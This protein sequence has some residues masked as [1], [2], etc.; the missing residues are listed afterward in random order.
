VDGHEEVDCHRACRCLFQLSRARPPGGFVAR[1]SRSVGAHERTDFV[2]D[3]VKDL[4]SRHAPSKERG[5]APKRS[6]LGLDL[7]EM[8]TNSSAIRS[9]APTLIK[10]LTTASEPPTSLA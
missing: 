1:K 4:S 3:R 2:A 8:R 7:R 5:D 6:L 10:N 9:H